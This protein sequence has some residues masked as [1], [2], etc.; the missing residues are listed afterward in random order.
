MTAAVAVRDTISSP[1]ATVSAVAKAIRIIMMEPVMHAGMDIRR[2]PRAMAS[3]VQKAIRI[4]ITAS[5]TSAITAACMTVTLVPVVRRALPII[6]M[7]PVM[8]AGMGIRRSRQATASAARKVIRIIMMASATSA[9]RPVCTTVIPAHV[10][11]GILPSITMAPVIHAVRGLDN[12]RQAKASAVPKA[13]RIII[14]S[15]AMHR[16]SQRALVPK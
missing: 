2:S 9:V 3:A 12:T 14:T 7:E 4:I 6:M 11:R 10:V 16:Q 8:H 15:N 13:I 5:A 1:R